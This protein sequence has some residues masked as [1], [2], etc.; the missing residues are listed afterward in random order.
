MSYGPESSYLLSQYIGSIWEKSSYTPPAVSL[1]YNDGEFM[2]VVDD[3]E[4]FIRF[5]SADGQI[6]VSLNTNCTPNPSKNIPLESVYLCSKVDAIL[7]SPTEGPNS[8]RDLFVLKNIV[9][10]LT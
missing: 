3:S 5:M 7:C 6:F 9:P 4:N 2:A 1:L 8:S 10:L